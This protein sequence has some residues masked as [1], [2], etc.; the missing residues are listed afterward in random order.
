MNKKKINIIISGVIRNYI[1][2]MYI[3]TLYTI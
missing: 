3:E 2:R 1:G